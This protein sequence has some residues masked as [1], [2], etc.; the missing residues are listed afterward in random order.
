MRSRRHASRAIRLQLPGRAV[1]VYVASMAQQ[2]GVEPALAPPPGDP[3]FPLFDSLRAAAALS[4]FFAHAFA[5]NGS[6]V[7]T[8]YGVYA[9][10]L[11][12]GVAIF[13]VISGVSIDPSWPRG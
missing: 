5:I 10:H 1:P 13:F 8:W 11:E 4:I 7:G 3:R 9:D 6:R 12:S 2:Q